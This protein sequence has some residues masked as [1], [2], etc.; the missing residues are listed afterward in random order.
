MLP[1]A[2]ASSNKNFQFY[3]VLYFN[4]KISFSM[5][6][7]QEEMN[8]DEIFVKHNLTHRKLVLI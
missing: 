2:P 4:D 3:T 5:V 1:S 8:K 7:S 6:V